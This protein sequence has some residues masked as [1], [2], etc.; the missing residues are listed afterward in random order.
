MS[1]LNSAAGSEVYRLP[2]EAEW[3]Y[4]CRAGTTTRWS[5]GDDESQLK[6]YAWYS[7]NTCDVGEC[8]PHRVGTKRANAWGL[9]DMHGNV[10]EWVQD[11]YS[12]NY[13]GG[14]P[15]IDP[16]GPQA[17]SY[18]D[19]SNGRGGDFG[20]ITLGVQSGS[21]ADF[22]SDDRLENLGFRLMRRAD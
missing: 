16:L 12:H 11:M 21:R 2:S 14:A 3:E 9:Y 8:Y 20:A 5:F 10:W 15:L 7:D 18:M 4:A 19:P 1:R 17:D 13:L 6:H 22:V